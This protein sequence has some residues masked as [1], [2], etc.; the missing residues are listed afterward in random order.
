MIGWT[1]TTVGNDNW[2]IQFDGLGIKYFVWWINRDW[3]TCTQLIEDLILRR[4]DILDGKGSKTM[5][6]LI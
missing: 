5:E 3:M 4:N 6:W 2:K 1:S